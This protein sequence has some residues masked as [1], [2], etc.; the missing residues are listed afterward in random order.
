MLNFANQSVYWLAFLYFSN[1]HN[2]LAPPLIA[3]GVSWVWIWYTFLSHLNSRSSLT[4]V[5]LRTF[6]IHVSFYQDNGVEFLRH[7]EI[8]SIVG[9]PLVPSCPANH[10]LGPP[11][12]SRTS[13]CQALVIVC[14]CVG[15]VIA[16]CDPSLVKIIGGTSSVTW[17]EDL[18]GSPNIWFL[19]LQIS[20]TWSFSSISIT[21]CWFLHLAEVYVK[22]W[23]F[24]CWRIYN[25]YLIN[26]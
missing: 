9:P 21:A 24:L 15:F 4:M 1:I 16:W 11:L 13:R 12:W 20:L 6:M 3:F 17:P 19:D 22:I 2:V 5:C 14:H 25:S 23:D 18:K 10:S 7:L 26:I 8:R